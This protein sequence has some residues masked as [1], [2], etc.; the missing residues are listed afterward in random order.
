MVRELCSW[1]HNT[2]RGSR[3]KFTGMQQ[4]NVITVFSWATLLLQQLTYYRLLKHPLFLTLT[5]TILK[6]HQLP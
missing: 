2:V 4:R 6:N 1:A 5:F 3:R